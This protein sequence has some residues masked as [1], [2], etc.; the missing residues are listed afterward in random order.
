MQRHRK[1]VSYKSLSEKP[2]K[3]AYV[4]HKSTRTEFQDGFQRSNCL[5]FTSL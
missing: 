2:F 5:G 3:H 4:L 1:K